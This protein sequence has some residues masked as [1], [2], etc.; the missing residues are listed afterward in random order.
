MYTPITTQVGFEQE[1]RPTSGTPSLSPS[2]LQDMWANSGGVGFFAGGNMDRF[3][4]F[5]SRVGKYAHQVH[6]S[7]CLAL[8]TR[9]FRVVLSR[10]L[11]TCSRARFPR[12]LFFFRCVNRAS[13]FVVPICR[14][15][16][17]ETQ[18]SPVCAVVILL[19]PCGRC[20][21][22]TAEVSGYSSTARVVRR[23]A[24]EVCSTLFR[25]GKISSAMMFSPFRQTPSTRL[26]YLVLLRPFPRRQVC[27]WIIQGDQGG[28]F[29]GGR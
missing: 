5:V 18:A 25:F 28:S 13:A 17:P 29:A 15:R 9:L 11:D 23:L 24:G 20:T 21:G 3:S 12:R 27:G 26:V 22:S 7:R 19:H 6:V 10:M 1:Q 8:S 4:L 2:C 16:P 14:S